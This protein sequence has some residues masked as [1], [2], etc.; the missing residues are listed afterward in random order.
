VGDPG[1]PGELSVLDTALY[2]GTFDEG[3]SLREEA[4]MKVQLR[5]LEGSWTLPADGSTDEPFSL[6]LCL[7][8]PENQLEPR[9]DGAG[10]VT[11]EPWGQ[12][13][14]VSYV[15]PMRTV[16]G[17]LWTL[18]LSMY[19]YQPSATA[20]LVLDGL[21]RLPE[22]DELIAATL[23][24]GDCQDFSQFRRFDS[25]RF[26]TVRRERHAVEFQGGSLLLDLHIG[27]SL[28]ST[29][30]ALFVRGTGVLDGTSFDQRDYWHLIYNPEHHH[31]ER[32]FIVLFDQPIAGACGLRASNFDPWKDPPP[33]QLSTVDCSL[34]EIDARS[35]TSET[36]E[37]L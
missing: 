1:W 3:R 25:C 12:G 2:C 14:L 15:Q 8:F 19:D 22:S 29:E 4:A 28:A 21:Y 5:F 27:D 17:S 9:M 18:D 35:V 20:S 6:P 33:A 30:P 36:W 26:D 31:F 32:D 13:R 7:R 16:T 23:C 37:R 10:M 34:T 11:V 24:P